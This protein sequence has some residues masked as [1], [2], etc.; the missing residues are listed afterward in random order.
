M[1]VWCGHCPPPCG[2]DGPVAASVLQPQ[3]PERH[4]RYPNN[5]MLGCGVRCQEH[6]TP[7][8]GSTLR[9]VSDYPHTVFTVLE[10]GERNPPVGTFRKIR[11]I[12]LELYSQYK[13]VQRIENH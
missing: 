13:W 8:L 5:L 11:Y 3:A 6:Y 12:N 2:G 7:R 1:Y 10:P 4:V 9:I